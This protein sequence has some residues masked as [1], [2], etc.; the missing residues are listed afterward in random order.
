MEGIINML[1]LIRSCTGHV[2]VP[3]VKEN[4]LLITRNKCR[5]GS[6]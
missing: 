1:H 2:V 4:R 3:E 6:D 5:D